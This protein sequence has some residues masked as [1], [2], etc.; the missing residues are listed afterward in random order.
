MAH[1][2]DYDPAEEARNKAAHEKWMNTVEAEIEL[3]VGLS[4]AERQVSDREYLKLT[5][6][7]P[8]WSYYNDRETYEEIENKYRTKITLRDISWREAQVF[9]EPIRIAHPDQNVSLYTKGPK[10]SWIGYTTWS[11]QMEMFFG[12][13]VFT[14]YGAKLKRE[15]NEYAEAEGI[16]M[17]WE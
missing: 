3:I 12:Y 8:V 17:A 9:A 4:P 10:G 2:N 5:G 7:D 11:D 6:N 1:Y 15:R 13:D 16:P 14:P